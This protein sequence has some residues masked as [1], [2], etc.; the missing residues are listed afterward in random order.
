MAESMSNET[1]NSN[2]ISSNYNNTSTNK[3]INQS[4]SYVNNPVESDSDNEGSVEV[5]EMQAIKKTK[6][7]ASG[8]SGAKNVIHLHFN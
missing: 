6:T 3:I 7:V 2:N 8:D 4:K 1:S 5:K